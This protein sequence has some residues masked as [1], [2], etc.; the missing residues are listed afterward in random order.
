MLTQRT[1]GSFVGSDMPILVPVCVEEL[2]EPSPLMMVTA[3]WLD[4]DL[5]SHRLESQSRHTRI[6]PSVTSWI[7]MSRP[8]GPRLPR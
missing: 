6:V 2:L 4:Q 3:S 7:V 5:L 8:R 1:A